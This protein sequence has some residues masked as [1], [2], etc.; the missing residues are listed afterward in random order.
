MPSATPTPSPTFRAS[1]EHIDAVLTTLL[2]DRL[3][4]SLEHHRALERRGLTCKEIRSHGY[5]S[6]PNEGAGTVAA[7]SLAELDLRGVPGFFCEGKRWRMVPL[8]PGFFVPVRDERLRVVGLQIRRDVPKAGKYL[9]FSSGNK[10]GGVGSGAPVHFALPHLLPTANEI[11][12]TEGGLKAN[13]IAHFTGSPVVAAAGVGNFGPDFAARL[14]ALA[15]HV[16]PVLAFDMDWLVKPQVAAALEKLKRGLK[17]AG[18][19]FKVRSWPS[20][21]KGLDDFL[22]AAH[23]ASSRLEVAA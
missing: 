3:T 23:G 22:L 11:L 19:R 5:A 2:R 1:V 20:R 7:A 15:P 18:F 14:Y 12:I 16:V 4:L 9:W 21:F 17:G 8:P 13:V 6:V 10:R